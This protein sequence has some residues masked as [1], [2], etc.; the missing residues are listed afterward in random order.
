MDMD[1]TNASP[2]SRLKIEHASPGFA[3]HATFHR[4]FV[5]NAND[6]F[7]FRHNTTAGDPTSYVDLARITSM[8][9]VGIGTQTR[10]SVSSPPM[11]VANWEAG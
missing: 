5:L 8:G 11:P 4:D 1:G 10:I 2:G 7:Q 9:K 3:H 6:G